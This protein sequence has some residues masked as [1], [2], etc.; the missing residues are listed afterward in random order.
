MTDVD[1]VFGDAVHCRLDSD[2]VATVEIRR[3]P[4]NF[5][6][7]PLVASLAD[8]YEALDLVDG[9][10]AIVLCSEGRHFCAGA[11]LARLEV[12]T[13][14]NSILDRLSDLRFV[15][16]AETRIVGLAFRSPTRTPFQATSPD[17]PESACSSARGS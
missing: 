2:H 16:D 11:H 10:R 12:R 14:I 6:D 17:P 1:Q 4:S 9:C 13:A 15:P 3:P 8:C 5:L 7:L